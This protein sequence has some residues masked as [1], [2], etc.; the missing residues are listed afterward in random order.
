[1]NPVSNRWFCSVN[2]NVLVLQ[3]LESWE[4]GL[5]PGV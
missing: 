1:M 4:T 5:T 2:E 3:E